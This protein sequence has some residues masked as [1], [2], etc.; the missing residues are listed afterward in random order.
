MCE[1]QHSASADKTSADQGQEENYS[2][3]DFHAFT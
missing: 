2:A 1:Q 3:T